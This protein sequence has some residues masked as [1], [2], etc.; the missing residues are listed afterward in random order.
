MYEQLIELLGEPTKIFT[1]D[2]SSWW[3][4]V[5]PEQRDKAKE[6]CPSLIVNGVYAYP[7]RVEGG[8]LYDICYVTGK[9]DDEPT[10]LESVKFFVEVNPGCSHLTINNAL[11]DKFPACHFGTYLA[12]LIE[13][14][15]IAQANFWIKETESFPKRLVTLYFPINTKLS[16]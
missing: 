11:K 7:N 13:Q 16:L 10:L 14:R 3:S 6:I 2:T 1:Q 5:T 9:K 15:Q 12:T 4:H 8:Q